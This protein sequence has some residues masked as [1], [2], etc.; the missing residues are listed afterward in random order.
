LRRGWHPSSCTLEGV[1]SGALAR[2]TEIDCES[3]FFVVSFADLCERWG[4]GTVGDGE[5]DEAGYDR[6]G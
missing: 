3:I 6:D 4:D 2:V 5:E 1:P